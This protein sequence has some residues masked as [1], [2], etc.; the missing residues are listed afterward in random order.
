MRYF[1]ENGYWGDKMEKRL[2]QGRLTVRSVKIF[3]DG[4]FVFFP[5]AF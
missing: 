5:T 1:D 2:D 3:A 4:E